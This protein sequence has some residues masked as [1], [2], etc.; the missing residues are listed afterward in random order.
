MNIKYNAS[1]TLFLSLLLFLFALPPVNIPWL[2]FVSLVPLFVFAKHEPSLKKLLMTGWGVGTLYFLAVGYPLTSLERWWWVSEQSAFLWQ[3]KVYIFT[4][5]VFTASVIS[6]LSFAATALAY[7]G[8]VKSVWRFVFPP[9]LWAAFEYFRTFSLF[10]FF[11]IGTFGVLLAK[12]TALIQIADT[13]SVYGVS[14]AVIL[15]NILVAEAILSKK[16]RRRRLVAVTS[17]LLLIIYTYGVI[18]IGSGNNNPTQ[19]LNVA[20]VNVPLST[21]KLAGKRGGEFF[22]ETLFTALKQNPDMVIFPENT[23]PD[24]VI[25]E[26]SKSLVHPTEHTEEL[27]NTLISKSAEYP[28]TSII[29]GLHTQTQ[30][31]RYNSVTIITGGEITRVYHKRF[32]LPFA[33]YTPEMFSNIFTLAEPLTRGRDNQRLSINGSNVSFLICAESLKPNAVQ[34]NS[35]IINIANDAIFKNGSVADYMLLT[36]KVRAV[37]NRSFLIRSTKGRPPTV[38]TPAGVVVTPTIPTKNIFL[39]EF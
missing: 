30:N 19:N 6:G 1:Q 10:G 5:V 14:A 23:L 25:D 21:E 17:L 13:F 33:E 24:M 12:D 15:V 38:L 37:E 2:L 39:F 31:K 26:E 34:K 35:L 32:L 18:Q 27:F 22:K 4:L 9:V 36:A 29:I 16:T 3:N 20:V 28:D 7:R 8:N 11:G